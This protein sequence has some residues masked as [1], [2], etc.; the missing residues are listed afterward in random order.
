MV[1]KRQFMNNSISGQANIHPERQSLIMHQRAYNMHTISPPPGLS[2][3]PPTEIPPTTPNVEDTATEEKLEE[4]KE[5]KLEYEEIYETPNPEPAIQYFTFNAT[6]ITAPT[7]TDS[8]PETPPTVQPSEKSLFSPTMYLF[9]VPT[10]NPKN[11]ENINIILNSIILSY[12]TTTSSQAPSS[13]PPS[14]NPPSMNSTIEPEMLLPLLEEVQHTEEDATI[15]QILLS[16]FINS[17]NILQTLNTYL[18]Q[19]LIKGQDDKSP[20]IYPSDVKQQHQHPSNAKDIVESIKNKSEKSNKKKS[21]N[22]N[23]NQ[24]NNKYNCKII[25]NIRKQH[26]N[27]K[28]RRRKRRGRYPR[29]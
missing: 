23:I 13:S 10:E 9:D 11:T 28:S 2:P 24:Q 5:E 19:L 29:L 8:P 21:L 27:N 3:P 17:E 4:E 25:T 26:R 20:T 22:L 14:S 6:S 18:W 15:N 1:E 12:I 16:N 7:P